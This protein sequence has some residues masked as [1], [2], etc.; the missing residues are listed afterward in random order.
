MPVVAAPNDEVALL[1]AWDRACGQPAWRRPLLV[2]AALTGERVPEDRPLGEVSARLLALA[3]DRFTDRLDGVVPCPRCG[4]PLELQ[5]PVPDVLAL[6]PAGP[7]PEPF[8]VDGAGW[9]VTVRLPTP[10]DLAAA[11]AAAGDVDEVR[12]LLLA[13]LVVATDPAGAGT[14]PAVADVIEAA[15]AER[16]PLGALSVTLTC[17][18]CGCTD[19]AAVDVAGWWMSIVEARIRRIVAE[20]DRLA[21]AYGW[22]EREALAVGPYR[23]AWY[24]ELI[25]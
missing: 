16:D 11:A 18:D 4:Q 2:A 15:M 7:D 10:A 12:R 1:A 22:S 19:S 24:L 6:A 13:R 25:G 3:A 8:T 5:L 14:D 17:P 21:R 20:V 9:R 23:R